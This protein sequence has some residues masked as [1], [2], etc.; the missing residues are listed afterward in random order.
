MSD[1]GWKKRLIDAIEARGLTP[2]RVSISAGKG[3]GYVH[4][5][6]GEGKDPSVTNLLMVCE[7]AGISGAF[8]IFGLDVD[9]ATEEL[10]RKM[11]GHPEKRDAI[12]KLLGDQDAV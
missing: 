5:L 7:A 8:V 4:S 2:R 6:L 12:L 10:M 9:P 3:P 1:T 11:Q